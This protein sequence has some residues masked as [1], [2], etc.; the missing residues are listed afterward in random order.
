MTNGKT[1]ISNNLCKALG[2]FSI[3]AASMMPLPAA[4]DSHSIGKDQDGPFPISKLIS[5][6]QINP[7]NRIVGFE[8]ENPDT[9]TSKGSPVTITVV[10][11]NPSNDPIGK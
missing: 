2:L 10:I 8:V 7:V 6:R 3:G 5:S 1:R 9:L 4:A 11:V